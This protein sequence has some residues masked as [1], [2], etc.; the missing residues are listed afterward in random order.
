M[1]HEKMLT[2]GS[3]LILDREINRLPISKKSTLPV[4]GPL[5]ILLPI[6]IVHLQGVSH[7]ILVGG[8]WLSFFIQPVLITYVLILSQPLQKAREG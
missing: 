4:I 5:L 8:I 7:C 1:W 2:G 6:G 3:S